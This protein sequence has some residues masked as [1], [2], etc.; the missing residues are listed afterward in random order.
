MTLIQRYSKIVAYFNFRRFKLLFPTYG[1]LI[2]IFWLFIMVKILF[3]QLFLP[4][5]STSDS[6]FGIIRFC[7][8]VTNATI[9]KYTKISWTFSSN[10]N[11]QKLYN[12][13]SKISYTVAIV[14]VNSRMVWI[15]L[16]YNKAGTQ[17]SANDHYIASNFH[18]YILH[19][20]ILSLLF[21][22]L[23]FE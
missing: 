1:F 15:Y 18:V 6:C 10:K 2:F 13:L 23:N 9:Y 14:I 3:K 21:F 20:N 7:Q 4:Q 16:F 5:I 19:S 17:L 12:F 8:N 22:T 11:L